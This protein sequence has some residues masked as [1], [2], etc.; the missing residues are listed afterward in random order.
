MRGLEEPA[1]CIHTLFGARVAEHESNLVILQE[2]TP[3]HPQR[4]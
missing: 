3:Q 1:L 4:A 2:D